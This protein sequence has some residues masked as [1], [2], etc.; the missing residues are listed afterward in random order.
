MRHQVGSFFLRASLQMV[1]FTTSGRRSHSEVLL[2]PRACTW[3]QVWDFWLIAELKSVIS[4]KAATLLWPLLTPWIIN[5]A[6]INFNWVLNAG[7][8][9]SLKHWIMFKVYLLLARCLQPQLVRGMVCMFPIK[10]EAGKGRK[11]RDQ[12]GLASG[13]NMTV[14]RN[15]FQWSRA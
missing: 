7:P 13:Y 15:K 3:S 11:E 14:R 4:V 5:S 12:E 6:N 2:S 9:W 1:T 8:F 10:T